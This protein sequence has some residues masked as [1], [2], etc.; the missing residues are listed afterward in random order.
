MLANVDLH[1]RVNP[2]DDHRN[3]GL[4]E[5]ECDGI[6]V[7][8]HQKIACHSGGRQVRAH[9]TSVSRRGENVPHVYADAVTG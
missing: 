8:P 4:V 7:A 5:V 3:L 2:G 6:E 1:L 9:I